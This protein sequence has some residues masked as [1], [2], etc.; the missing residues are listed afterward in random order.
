MAPGPGPPGASVGHARAFALKAPATSATSTTPAQAVADSIGGNAVHLRPRR[1]READ[2][3][4]R[5]GASSPRPWCRRVEN[6]RRHHRLSRPPAPEWSTPARDDWRRAHHT[7]PGWH[8]PGLPLAIQTM[9]AKGKPGPSST[10]RPASG[11]GGVPGAAAAPR[12]RPA[13]ANYSKTG[14][15]LRRAGAADPMQLNGIRRRSSI[16]MWEPMLSFR[17]GPRGTH[18]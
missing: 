15:V 3:R 6:K 11:V 18:A 7:N 5:D 17:P 10:C 8:L 14:P 16:P 2:R 9:R 12:R 13:S 4:R 1:A